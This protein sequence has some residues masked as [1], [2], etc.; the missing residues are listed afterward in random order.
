VY[1]THFKDKRN[2]VIWP[3][4]TRLP[5]AE[6]PMLELVPFAIGDML[7]L[8]GKRIEVLS[9]AHRAG[10]GAGDAGGLIDSGWPGRRPARTALRPGSAYN[11]D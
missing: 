9:G 8:N 5:S 1:Y 10:G 11:G 6:R 7:E 3:D 2:G 4:F